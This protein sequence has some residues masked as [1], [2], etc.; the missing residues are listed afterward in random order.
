[1]W[2]NL[3]ADFPGVEV[4]QRGFGGS[5]LSDAVY[6]APRIVLKYRPRLIVLY[7]GDNDLANGKSP[8]TVFR[9]YR[10]FIAEVERALPRTRVAFVSIKPSPSRWAVVDKARAVN[11]KIREFV[12]K[13]PR[14]IYVDAFNPM[15][16][17]NRHPRPELYADDSLHMTTA[18]YALWR[19]LL[20][21]IV[22]APVAR[23]R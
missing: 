23:S 21:P 8:G 22:R 9:D 13:H 1:M 14:H 4:L 18:G 19:N 5:E 3:S 15:L 6:Y 12:A 10:D 20:T 7:A 17:E 16:G 2:P 11:A